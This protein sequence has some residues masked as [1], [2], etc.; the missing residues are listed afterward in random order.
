MSAKKATN[1]ASDK[2]NIEVSVTTGYRG[3]AAV[4]IP[5][6]VVPIDVSVS[7]STTTKLKLEVDL[8]EYEPPAE[9]KYRE[10]QIFILDTGTGRLLPSGS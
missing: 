1:G 9:A 4:P 3:G 7:S 5:V 6:P 10:P 2:L 8:R